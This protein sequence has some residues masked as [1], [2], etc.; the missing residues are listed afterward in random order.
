MIQASI[1]LYLENNGYVKR[2]ELLAHLHSIGHNIPDRLMRK[3]IERMVVNDGY[4][5]LSSEKG[6]KIIRNDEEYK[7][8]I[9]YLDLKAK[10]I[11]IRKNC[12]ISSYESTKKFVNQ[13]NLF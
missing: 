10:A 7:Q 12:L 9:S 8:A 5:I 11:A 2:K 13:I 6:Y 1:L 3:E 4:P